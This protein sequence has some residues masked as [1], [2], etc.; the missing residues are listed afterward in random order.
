LR[1]SKKGKSAVRTANPDLGCASIEIEGAFFAEF[2]GGIGRGKDLNTDLRGAGE[3]ERLL[4][5]LWPAGSKPRDIDGPDAAR[6]G[7]RALG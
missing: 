3:Q 6:S 2:G 7:N 4:S 1:S 5:N